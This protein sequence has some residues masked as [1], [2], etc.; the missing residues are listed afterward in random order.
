MV[1]SF[2]GNLSIP[3]HAHVPPFTSSCISLI[4]NAA[5]AAAIVCNTLQSFGNEYLHMHVVAMLMQTTAG[6][7]VIMIHKAGL[8]ATHSPCVLQGPQIVTIPTFDTPKRYWIVPFLDAYLNY[9]GAL[10]SNFNTSA[11][12]YLVVGRGEFNSL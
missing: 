11:G 1:G 9:Y 12:Q 10:G 5:E 6:G 4:C 3:A 7:H 8:N 2:P